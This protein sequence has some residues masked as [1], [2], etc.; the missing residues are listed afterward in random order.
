MR[1]YL[2]YSWVTASQEGAEEPF[3]VATSAQIRREYGV[4]LGMRRPNAF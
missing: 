4:I 1:E 3:R 2:S